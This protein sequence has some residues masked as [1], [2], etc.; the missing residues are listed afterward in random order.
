MVETPISGRFSVEVDGIYRRLR[1][2]NDPSVVVTWQVRVL[3][4]YTFSSSG[5]RPFPEA[6][7][8]F[9][10]TGNL[11]SS[12][13][14]HFGITTGVGANIRLRQLNISPA[15]RYSYWAPDGPPL[16]SPPTLTKQNQIELVVGFSF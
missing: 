2:P 16:A 10:L 13:P 6:G 14:S 4:K 9:R 12:N 5:L 8:S 15:I 3:A 1:Y 11:N 7:P